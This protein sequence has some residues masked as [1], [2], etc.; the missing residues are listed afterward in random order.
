VDILLLD[1]D[2]TITDRDTTRLLVFALLLRRPWR[3]FGVM[4]DL[5]RLAFGGHA[6]DIQAAKDRCV[7][8]LLRG[9]GEGQIGES[10]DGYRRR[11]ASLIRPRMAVLMGERAAAGQRV[12]VVT[13]SAE[14]AVRRA[15]EDFPVTVLGTRFATQG[16]VFTGKV[17]GAACYGPAKVPHIL[18]WVAGQEGEPRFLEGWSDSLADLP[19]LELAERRVW[20]CDEGRAQ[21]FRQRD[22]QGEIVLVD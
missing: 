15:L 14:I 7:G 18:E 21:A 4:A 10:V 19:M 13:A 8:A 11:V 1:F 2:G 3:V 6:A 20:V 17:A 12:L 16:G 9:L 22:P 5:G